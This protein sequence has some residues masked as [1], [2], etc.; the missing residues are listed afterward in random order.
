MGKGVLP[1]CYIK[2]AACGREDS[3]SHSINPT[4]GKQRET[5]VGKLN[6]NS[7]CWLEARWSSKTARTHLLQ[8]FSREFKQLSMGSTCPSQARLR[9]CGCVHTRKG[10]GSVAH[11]ATSAFSPSSG[12]CGG[13]T[14]FY[15]DG[16]THGS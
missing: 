15:N 10:V 2:R 7:I 5:E 3:G 1:F 14:V 12:S 4:G 13:F 16:G 8:D 6:P 9:G 11:I